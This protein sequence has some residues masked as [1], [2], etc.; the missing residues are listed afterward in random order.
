M[1]RNH[2]R[3]V[4]RLAPLADGSVLFLKRFFSV[5][6]RSDAAGRAGEEA[7]AVDRFSALGL[8]GPEL[9]ARGRDEDGTKAFLLYR[10]PSGAESFA[11][12][13]TA[14]GDHEARA[15]LVRTACLLG[16]VHDARVRLPD[17]LARHVIVPVEGDPYFIDLTRA[18]FGLGGGISAR[19]DLG[20]LAA[21]LPAHLVSRTDRLRALKSYLESRGITPSRS[22]LR[23][24]YRGVS[25]GA[26]LAGKRGRMPIPM[27]LIE[28][29]DAL[30]KAYLD[31]SVW[32][33]LEIS[34]FVSP[35]S[36][37]D[38]PPVASR[39]RDL[40]ERSNYR[41]V[42]KESAFYLKVHRERSGSSRMSRGRKEWNHH[43]RLYAAGIAV[44]VPI[45]WGQGPGYSFFLSR[46]LGG[47]TA[48]AWAYDLDG[49]T[50]VVRRKMVRTLGLL[51]IRLHRCGFYHRDLY[52][53]HFIVKG[54]TIFLI[55]LER[56]LERPLFEKHR[57]VKDLAAMLYASLDTEATRT[58]RLRCFR[59]YY[60]GGRLG[61]RAKSLIRTIEAKARR[62]GARQRRNS[63]RNREGESGS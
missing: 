40:A 58:D 11:Q 38:P 56:L 41:I 21:T 31:K 9:A 34:G 33:N 24:W 27:E 32:R 57:R 48:E 30:G 45:G 47:R 4:L 16:R 1:D 43:L 44:P 14:L 13:L 15:L 22:K 20:R 8:P 18:R 25:R 60:G 55:D 36:F 37:R 19:N 28:V 5:K 2:G 61:P 35:D 54:N 49:M 17:L 29:R 59:A 46:D 52:L 53:C 12:R 63:R 10:V 7:L 39:L 50:P 51:A 6:R 62:I 23:S 3:E 42:L 26:R